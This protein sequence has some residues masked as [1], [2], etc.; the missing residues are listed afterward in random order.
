LGIL[1]GR[2]PGLRTRGSRGPSSENPSPRPFP[3][4]R[5]LLPPRQ[6]LGPAT[7]R[8]DPAGGPARPQLSSPS[9][10]PSR[11]LPPPTC[12]EST[13]GFVLGR[14]MLCGTAALAPARSD[15]GDEERSPRR[16]QGP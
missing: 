1:D 14:M 8:K 10:H 12:A 16:N 4:V 11:C 9:L 6:L 7:R 15:L 2:G 5:P 3:S 13:G